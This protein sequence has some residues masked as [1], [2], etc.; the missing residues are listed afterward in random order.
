LGNFKGRQ[1]GNNGSPAASQVSRRPGTRE[2]DGE[3]ITHI[4]VV[5]DIV[6]VVLADSVTGAYFVADCVVIVD[7]VSC[8]WYCG[9]GVSCV[10]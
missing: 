6:S 2:T 9:G 4:A 3:G 7:S 8:C 5:V 10:Y 1:K